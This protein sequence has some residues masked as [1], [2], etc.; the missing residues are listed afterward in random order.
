MKFLKTFF[1]FYINASIHVAL[2]IVA[3]TVFTCL[4]YGLSIN[5]SLL[6]F[7]FL[8]SITGYNFVKYAPI[9]KLYHKRLTDNLKL[10]QIFSLFV[11]I[12]LIITSLYMNYQVILTSLGLGVLTLLYALPVRNKNLREISLI[13]VF[14]IALIW[15]GTTF[16]L[17]FLNTDIEWHNLNFVWFFD[18][19]ER[20]LWVIM[21]MIPFEIRDLKYDRKHIK[22]I[23]S[24]LGID[25]TKIFSI[26]ILLLLSLYRLIYNTEV[27]WVYMIIYLSLI[28][29]IAMSKEVQK[30]YY[31]S[32][33]I[34]ALP[35]FW[36]ILMWI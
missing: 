10:I 21:L 14:V 35:V 4:Q 2:A 36:M 32:F 16:L 9:A 12:G 22:T 29:C 27:L 30:P 24:E 20:F 18:F 3:L 7:I 25:A 1:R 8:S 31:S 23:V 15:T 26:S 11:F 5:Y 19:T 17:P 33:F 6:L 34:E 13:K 28:I